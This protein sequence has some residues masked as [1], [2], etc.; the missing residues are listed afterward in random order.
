L[1]SLVVVSV[2][3]LLARAIESTHYNRSVSKLFD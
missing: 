2:A 1:P 3:D